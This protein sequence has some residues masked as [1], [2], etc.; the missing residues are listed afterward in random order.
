MSRIDN[1]RRLLAD[2][3]PEEDRE[4]VSLFGEI[5]NFTVEQITNVINGQID[6]SNLTKQLIEITVTVDANGS[7]TSGAVFTADAN[8]SGSQVLRAL[9]LSTPTNYVN[10]AP[11]ITFTRVQSATTDVRYQ[12]QN[13]VGLVPDEQYQLLIELTPIS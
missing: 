10:S 1:T 6:Y 12:I 2:D 13:V 11:F 8:M 7:P 4:F 9:N 5:Y 3:Y